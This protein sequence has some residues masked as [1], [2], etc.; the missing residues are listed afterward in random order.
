M[1]IV[2]GREDGEREAAVGSISFFWS[3]HTVCVHL[4]NFFSLQPNPSYIEGVQN[5]VSISYIGGPRSLNS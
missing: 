2:L 5:C 4:R 1:V 3:P